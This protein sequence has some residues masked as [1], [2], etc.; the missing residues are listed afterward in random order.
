MIY[1]FIDTGKITDEDIRGAFKL[2]EG[3]W[4][5]KTDP[6]IIPSKVFTYNFVTKEIPF[7]YNV[8]KED[9]LVIGFTIVLPSSEEDMYDFINEKITEKE[10]FYRILETDRENFSCLYL[11]SA[12][13][14]ENYR[15]RGLAKKS[16]MKQ[17]EK[18]SNIYDIKYIYS[19]A[20]S[21]AGK[22]ICNNISEEINI[23]LIE[24]E[25]NIK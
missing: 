16:L 17:I 19:W 5:T 21:D 11:C 9:D 20:F 7:S 22:K 24:R 25:D 4:S 18:F 14:A 15:R 2:T 1:D 12:V 10:L 13:I 6:E 23:P 8:I 3:L